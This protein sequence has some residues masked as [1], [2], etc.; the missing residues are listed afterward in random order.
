MYYKNLYS[1]LTQIKNDST[2][3][4]KNGE[5]WKFRV[6]NNPW[7]NGSQWINPNIS[8]A[9]FTMS[10]SLLILNS[11]Y[12]EGAKYVLVLQSTP[13]I[14]QRGCDHWKCI[15]FEVQSF[16]FEKKSIMSTSSKNLNYFPTS[17]NVVYKN[18]L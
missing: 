7:N 13:I 14:K 6:S 2:F 17:I 16:Y 5:R 12:V 10:S 1:R 3:W 9:I 11:Q 15:E 4:T 8:G 18:W